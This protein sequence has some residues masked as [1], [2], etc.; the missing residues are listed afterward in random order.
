MTQLQIKAWLI[1]NPLED[2]QRETSAHLRRL[3]INDYLKIKY[4]EYALTHHA[5]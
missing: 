1:Y 4:H 5:S 3:N 2:L